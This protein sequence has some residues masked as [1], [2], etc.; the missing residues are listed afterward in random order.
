LRRDAGSGVASNRIDIILGDCRQHLAARGRRRWRDRSRPG[1]LVE[2]R[3]PDGCATAEAKIAA[4]IDCACRPSS[5]EEPLRI[6][7][8]PV[9]TI[10]DL[11]RLG[12]VA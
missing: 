12:R 9:T 11:T 5:R 2:R 3:K 7:A 8:P 6:G 1:L 4:A 10:R